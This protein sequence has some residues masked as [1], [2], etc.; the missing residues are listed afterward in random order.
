MPQPTQSPQTS[1]AADAA[2]VAGA[3]GAAG[4][5]AAPPAAAGA[6]IVTGGT[7]TVATAGIITAFIQFLS[8]LRGQHEQWLASQAATFAPGATPLGDIQQVIAEEMRLED[9]FAKNAADRLASQL[10]QALAIKDPAEREARVKQILADEERFAGQRVEA[11]AARALQALARLQLRRDSPAGA[12]WKLG[13][14]QKHTAGCLTMANRF[15]PWEVL[16]RIHPPRHYGCTSSLHG[17]GE[18]ILNRWM[19]P[20]DVPDTRDAIRAASGVS[21]MSEGEADALLRELDV[22]DRLLELGVDQQALGAI[23][24]KGVSEHGTTE[25]VQG[26]A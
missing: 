3:A 15:W 10:P 4:T 8:A 5:L 11:M 16:D 6:T 12:F 1:R 14:A 9:E 13:S 7:A 2:A 19:A 18:A 26:S 23:A 17:Y 21:M 24:L 22:R 20:G 25:V